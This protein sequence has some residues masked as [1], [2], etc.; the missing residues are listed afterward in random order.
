[1]ERPIFK[2]VGT[3]VQQLDTPALVVDLTILEHNIET[4]HAF[5]RQR[6]AKVR[7]HVESHRCPAIAHKQLAAGGT[8]GGIC[9]NTIGQAEVFTEH[10]FSDVL[11]ANEI[12]TPQ[13]IGRLCACARHAR[14]TVAVDH[15]QNIQDLSDAATA[16][17]VALHLVVEIHTRANRCGVEPGQPALDLAKLVQ[18]VPRLEFAGLMTREGPMP[19]EDPGKFAAESRQWIQKVLDTREIVERAG[20]PVHTVSVGGTYNYEIAGTMAGVTAVLA[21]T[22]ALMDARYAQSRPSFKAA[23]SVMT[24]VTSRPEPGSAIVDAGQKAV[25]IDT[26][27][28]VAQDLPGATVLALSA[29]HG[30]LRLQDEADSKVALADKIRL[31]PWDIGTCVNLYDYIHAV[32]DGKLE[33]VWDV[34]ARGRYR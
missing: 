29:E 15:P 4:L 5:F 18:Q 9:V 6:E 27:L 28:P 11:I 7:P 20:I 13:K 12:V 19:T 2:P 26:G 23:A 21:G 32:R 34:A 17:G 25:G 16:H 24:T 30:R 14:V 31:T 8:V 10:G 22:Y 3:P 33:V 1:M